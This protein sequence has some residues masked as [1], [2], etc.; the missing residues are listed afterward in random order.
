MVQSPNAVLNRLVQP[1][2]EVQRT[3]FATLWKFD[4]I[5]TEIL[6]N[7]QIELYLGQSRSQERSSF[8]TNIHR[9]CHVIS[10]KSIR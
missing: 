4:S 3:F 1:C 2:Q 8:S 5:L 7:F 10:A 6:F 9:F